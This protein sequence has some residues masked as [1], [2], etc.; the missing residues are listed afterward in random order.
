MGVL[1]RLS[2]IYFGAIDQLLKPKNEMSPIETPI[3]SCDEEKYGLVPQECS[4]FEA[5]CAMADRGDP[6]A[7]EVVDEM[8]KIM[9]DDKEEECRNNHLA[10]TEGIDEDLR[11]IADGLYHMPHDEAMIEMREGA[12]KIMTDL[13]TYGHVTDYKIVCDHINNSPF[14]V[15]QG[16]LRVDITF[17]AAGA[18]AESKT[19]GTTILSKA[20]AAPSH[21]P[22]VAPSSGILQGTVTGGAYALNTAMNNMVAALPQTYEM[23]FE[24]KTQVADLPSVVFNA[25]DEN[26]K[27]LTMTLHPELAQMSIY[28]MFKINM[29]INSANHAPHAFSAYAYVKKNNLERHFKFAQ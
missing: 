3:T 5:M 17:K 10:L 4:Y 8:V 20:T 25:Y 28:D 21:S 9:N 24:K 7:I 15:S 13:R 26:G 18:R 29:L 12:E 1:S 23:N 22:I 11:S 27:M 6:Y 14:D 2:S 16:K 19:G